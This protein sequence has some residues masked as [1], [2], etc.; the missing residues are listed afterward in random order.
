MCVCSVV[1]RST[2]TGTGTVTKRT[3]VH[4]DNGCPMVVPCAG[5]VALSSLSPKTF[6]DLLG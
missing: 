4:N 1:Q 3:P 5:V 6:A 2:K